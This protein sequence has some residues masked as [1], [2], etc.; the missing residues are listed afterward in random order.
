MSLA[1]SFLA[2]LEDIEGGGGGAAAKLVDEP[3]NVEDAVFSSL[4]QNSQFT[5]FM[6]R[7]VYQ[8]HESSKVALTRSSEDFL[9][10]SKC[11]A[12]LPQIDS[13]IYSV[14]KFVAE[15]YARRFPELEQIVLM[16]MDYLRVVDR[17][18]DIISLSSVSSADLSFLPTNLVVAITVTASTSASASSSSLLSQ[19]DAVQI[20]DRIRWA[21]ELGDKKIIILRFLSFQMPRFAPNLNALLG[22]HLAA[23]LIASAG[24]MESLATMPSQNI[25]AVGAHKQGLSGLS[26]A[27]HNAK[28]SLICQSDL[29]LSVA[30]HSPEVK[31]RAIR[32]VLGK[33]SIAARVDQ[34]NKNDLLGLTGI[35]L[36]QEIE[37][38]LRKASEPPAARVI[39]PLSIP[40]DKPKQRRG[41]KRLR[42]WKEKYGETEIHKK[43][44]RLEFG[45]AQ[46]DLEV[47]G[48]TV[49]KRT[50]M[51]FTELG[52]GRIRRQ[53]S[54]SSRKQKFNTSK[55]HNNST[56]PRDQLAFTASG[57][58]IPAAAATKSSS[59][60]ADVFSSLSFAK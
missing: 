15:K 18:Q 5:D 6:N 24:G 47:D 8:S 27:F 34:F 45:S 21:L 51:A 19:S 26:A 28:V 50:G 44:G 20:R 43:A 4:L 9:L 42:N 35:K 2:D 13:E 29:V 7:I 16:P 11:N 32:L 46:G 36:R 1:D 37:E 10:I 49:G 25:E 23:Q 59:S 58:H 60:S 41:G 53:Q 22:S 57:I 56:N 17:L 48:L 12:F 38:A 33:T 30:H 3:R 40:D 39:K 55:D 54:A 14:Y 52:G 31:K